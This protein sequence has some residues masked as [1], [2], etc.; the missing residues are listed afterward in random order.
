MINCY[1]KVF[2]SKAIS[3]YIVLLMIVSLVFMKYSME[4]YFYLFGIISVFGFFHFSNVLPQ[5]WKYIPDISFGKKLFITALI[6]RVVWVFVSALLFLEIYGDLFDFERFDSLYYDYLGHQGHELLKEGGFR[7]G[8][9][10]YNCLPVSD[11]GY[12]TYIAYMY[13]LLGDSVILFRLTKTIFSAWTCLL[14]YKLGSREFGSRVG[15]LAGIMC[16]LMPNLIYYCSIQVKEVEMVFLAVLFTERASAILKQNKFVASQTIILVF[17]GSLLFFFRTALAVTLFLAFFIAIVFTSSRVVGIGKKIIIG[18]LVFSVIGVAV[19]DAMIQ[20]VNEMY[21]NRNSQQQNMEWRSV[22]QNGN[23]FAKYA[24]RSVFAPLIFTIP[25]S[26]MVK[27]DG[28]EH[29]QFLNG[30][31]YTKN[32]TSFFTITAMFMLLMSG[33]WRKHVLVI[34]V[35]CGYLIIMAMSQFAQSERFHQPALPFEMMFAAY[36]LC[37]LKKKHARLFNFWLVFIFVAE[38]GWNWFKLAGRDLI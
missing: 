24:G 20:E 6:I 25:F 26:T 33:D 28:Q 15:R 5:K 18:V 37:N 1:P 36:A 11:Q 3:I 13:Y 19:G 22:R 34:G 10:A 27:I 38:I 23:K 4:F 7:E 16:M 17:V 29:T 21:N 8:F 31:N 14:I 32:I 35:L 2:T 12:P 9:E 30:A